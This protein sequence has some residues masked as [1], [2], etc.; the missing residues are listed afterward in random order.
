M[1]NAAEYKWLFEPTKDTPLTGK[2]S[3]VFC[4]CFRENWPRFNGIALHML[5]KLSA[6]NTYSIRPR[7]TCNQFEISICDKSRAVAV[8]PVSIPNSM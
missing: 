3:G 8:N 6:V 4:D 7:D 1:V 5:I 2:L